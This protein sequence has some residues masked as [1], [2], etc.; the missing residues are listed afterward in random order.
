MQRFPNVLASS[1]GV[2]SARLCSLLAT[3]TRPTL[4]LPVGT[5]HLLRFMS[6]DGIM[7]SFTSG[8]MDKRHEAVKDQIDRHNLS[9]KSELST[10]EARWKEQSQKFMQL[11]GNQPPAHAYSGRTVEIKT[12]G[13]LA[14]AY[15]QLDG[16]LARNKVRWTLKMTERHEKP[17]VKRRRLSSERWRKRFANEVRKKVQLVMKIRDRGA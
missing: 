1:F 17:G 3:S 2:Y 16:I 7:P 9:T 13:D 5:N 4:T 10:P 14:T 8:L 6:G 12:N 15:R 11:A